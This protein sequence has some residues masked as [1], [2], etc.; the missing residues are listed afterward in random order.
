MQRKE[1]RSIKNKYALDRQKTEIYTQ[2]YT[3]N[4]AELCTQHNYLQ[5]MDKAAF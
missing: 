1:R 4:S 2:L 5:Q 3:C